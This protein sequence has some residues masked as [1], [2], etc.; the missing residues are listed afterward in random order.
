MSM[1]AGAYAYDPN[2]ASTYAMQQTLS[3]MAFPATLTHA[4]TYPG[5]SD[6]ISDAAQYR[7][8]SISMLH[9]SPSVK[10]EMHSPV[11]P[12]LLFNDPNF[13]DDYKHSSSSDSE[14]GI[15]F[16]TDVDILMKAIQAKTA[17]AQARQQRPSKI[18]KE[19]QEAPRSSGR[20]KKRYQC[21]MPDCYKSFYQKTH[22]EIHTRAHTG[23]KPFLCKE[24]SCGQRFSQLGNLKT[25]ERRHT[26]ERPYN[27][28]VCGKT[29]A[30]RGNVRA[31][32][33]VHQQIKPFTCKLDDCG[34]QF[35][36]LGNLKSHQNKFHASALR[37][38]T[39]KFACIQEGDPVTTQDKELWEY[40]A[41]LYKNSNKGIKGR[42]KDRRISTVSLSATSSSLY[43]SIDSNAASSN[44]GSVTSSNNDSDRSS[45]SSSI[46]SD[47]NGQSIDH[48]GF[49]FDGS[50]TVGFAPRNPAFEDFVFPER[51]MF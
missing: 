18:V 6:M 19:L 24:P 3:S 14:L 8:S 39:Q 46:S 13:V 20:T 25:H 22:L 28:D 33:I 10:A 37:Y 49:G 36:Q 29:F 38:L 26:G 27:C 40:F 11:Q 5:G 23:V 42:G 30:Q 1:Q 15:T 34:K 4:A 48:A 21:S 9:R 35:T 17:P 31:H 44:H 7:R 32:M 50:T 51:K 2:A 45:R 41:S 43:P 47:S 16:S 12:S